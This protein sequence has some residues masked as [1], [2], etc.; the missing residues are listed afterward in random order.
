MRYGPA[1]VSV[2]VD[3]TTKHTAVP[4]RSNTWL[5]TWYSF[6]VVRVTIRSCSAPANWWQS[7]WA[8]SAR[9]P[10]AAAL[11]NEVPSVVHPAGWSMRHSPAAARPTSAGSSVKLD[12]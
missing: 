7:T 1:P 3:D 4:L 10:C 9:E 11:L 5:V 6:G 12:L 2:Q 8:T